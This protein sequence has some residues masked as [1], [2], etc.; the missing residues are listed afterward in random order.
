MGPRQLYKLG[1]TEAD[2]LEPVLSLSAANKTGITILGAVYLVISGMDKTGK[3][4][5][6]NQ[7]CYVA[8]GVDQFLLSREACQQLGMLPSSFPEVG[9]YEVQLGGDDNNEEPRD[10]S[11]DMLVP[12]FKLDITPCSPR[13]D[14]TCS[15]PRRAPPPL[16]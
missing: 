3:L 1:M 14:G 7:L 2:L 15:C 9:A 16:R 10:D 13:P 5:K 11:A 4:W 6:T 12:D 8:Q